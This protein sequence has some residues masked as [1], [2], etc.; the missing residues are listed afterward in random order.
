MIVG[1]IIINTEEE[2]T[3]TVFT[4]CEGCKYTLE[5][6]DRDVLLQLHT[7][8]EKCIDRTG[9]DQRPYRFNSIFMGDAWDL[10]W[11]HLKLSI[12]NSRIIV[13]FINSIAGCWSFNRFTQHSIEYHQHG[14][15]LQ[16]PKGP[17]RARCAL[18]FNHWKTRTHVYIVFWFLTTLQCLI[19]FNRV[20]KLRK[21]H[22]FVSPSVLLRVLLC[23]MFLKNDHKVISNRM[24]N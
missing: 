18:V 1:I 23:F 2:H 15:Y 7:I 21:G 17:R 24:A 3:G 20:G 11:N 4:L 5:E 12:A 10:T 22:L 13:N 8:S 19:P 9:Q 16:P 14:H 6:R